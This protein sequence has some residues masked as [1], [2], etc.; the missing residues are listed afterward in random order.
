MDDQFLQSSEF[1]V[2]VAVYNDS[3]EKESESPLTYNLTIV[4]DPL[5][6]NYIRARLRFECPTDYPS[7]SFIKCDITNKLPGIILDELQKAIDRTIESTPGFPIAFTIASEV[8]SVLIK[9]NMP[10]ESAR[11]FMQLAERAAEVEV[12]EDSESEEEVIEKELGAIPGEETNKDTFTEWWDKFTQEFMLKHTNAVM[13]VRP[14]EMP[15]KD[16]LAAKDLYT[17]LDLTQD[18]YRDAD[19]NMLSGRQYWLLR[20]LKNQQEIDSDAT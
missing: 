7:V 2:F 17:K 8:Q 10:L 4:P 20:K 12:R 18:N 6:T 19:G 9:Y 13:T 16:I 3:I 1:D 15:D 14:G 11:D 5:G